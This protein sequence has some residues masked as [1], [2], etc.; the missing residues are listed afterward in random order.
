M[1]QSRKTR[2]FHAADQ[3]LATGRFPEQESLVQQC[4]VDDAALAEAWLAEWRQSLSTRLGNFTSTPHNALPETVHSA[5]ERLW[6]LALDEAGE[7]INLVRQA[8]SLPA[9]E[10]VRACDDALRQSRG[11]RQELTKRFAELERR[12][13]GLSDKFDAL[14]SENKS[15]QHALSQ[16]RNERKKVEQMHAS[17]CQELTQLQKTYEDAKSTFDQRIDQEKRYSLE[18]IAKAEVDTRHY[19]NALEKLKDESGRNE[20]ALT[21]ELSGVQ[22]QLSRR[23][24]RIEKLETQVKSLESELKRSRSE[25][26]QQNREQTQLSA[27][28]LSERNRIKRYE[29][30]L[31]ELEA[32]RDALDRKLSEAT[33]EASRREQKLRSQLQALEEQ[34][35]KQR[36]RS[37]ATDK[38][39]AAMEE[40][41]RRLKQR[42]R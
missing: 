23:D 26:V 7:R 2:F 36:I 6:Q 11:E 1:D 21:R 31:K 42:N 3:M 19:R 14:D 29:S 38:R 13:E 5:M 12:Y 20:A 10:Q 8:Q 39:L 28:L 17:A 34:F 22:A 25:D 18:A 15:L 27:Q 9:E 30:Q 40:E 24:A 37:Q 33:L 35:D 41:N 32:T 16:E 4:P